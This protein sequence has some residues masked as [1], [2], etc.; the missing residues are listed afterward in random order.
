V[1]NQSR[2]DLIDSLQEIYLT[3][4]SEG[5]MCVSENLVLAYRKMYM[6]GFVDVRMFERV[7]C[8]C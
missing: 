5:R 3:S 7:K 8:G 2:V 6:C 4:K 1:Y